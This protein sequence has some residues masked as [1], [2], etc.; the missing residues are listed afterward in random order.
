MALLALCHN[1]LLVTLILICLF[2][3]TVRGRSLGVV[4]VVNKEV[5]QNNLNKGGTSH[6]EQNNVVAVKEEK[7][8]GKV[9]ESA[10]D[11]LTMDYTPAQKKPPIHN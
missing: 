7:N 3:A 2:S 10:N 9:T 6:E 8:H 4:V 1:R 5:E 11:L